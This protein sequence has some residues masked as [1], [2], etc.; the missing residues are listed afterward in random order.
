MKTESLAEQIDKLVRGHLAQ[1]QSEAEQAMRQAFAMTT[2]ERKTRAAKR[3]P[4]KR[5]EPKE[6]AELA[7]RLHARIVAEPGES[8][9]VHSGHLGMAVRDLHRPMTLL[10]RAGRLRT[11]GVRN[12]TRYYPTPGS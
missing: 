9:T 6:V 7:E 4:A 10:R 2:K 5:R 11:T 12:N 8:M 3:A 1:V